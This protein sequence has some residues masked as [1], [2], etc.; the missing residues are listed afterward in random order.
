MHHTT[1]GN[2]ASGAF[3]AFKKNRSD[4]HFTVDDRTVY[5]HIDT[6]VSSRSL[7]N[8][9]SGVETNRDSAIQIE[10]VGFAHIPKNPD[11]LLLLSKLLR[12]IEYIHDIPRVCPNGYPKTATKYGKDPG[13]HNRNANTWDTV[14]GHYGHCHV[15]E[16]THWDPAYSESEIQF[17]MNA[18]FDDMWKLVNPKELADIFSTYSIEL[19]NIETVTS[20]MPDH[21]IID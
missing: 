10:L 16:N 15:P 1:E 9:S 2:N 19:F 20:T 8:K 6:E 14:S 7:R 5:Q 3:S 21:A 13:N 17:I 11:S 4:P 12:W 18:E